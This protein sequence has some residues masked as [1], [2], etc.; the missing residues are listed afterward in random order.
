VPRSKRN[1]ALT[2]NF[3]MPLAFARAAK[4][5]SVS[6]FMFVSS[7]GVHGETS[8][9]VG[10]T[11]LSPLAAHDDYVASKAAA[12]KALL[13]AGAEIPDLT[14]IRPPMVYGPG[15]KGPMR[16]LLRCIE[17]GIP[18]P[19]GALTGNRRKMI[20]LSNLVDVLQHSGRR[21][22]AANQ[23]FLVADNEEL[24]TV[25]LLRLAGEACGRPAALPRIPL[26]M[27]NSA[28]RLP[29]VGSKLRRLFG[30]YQIDDGK[31]RKILHWTAPS[32]VLAELQRIYGTART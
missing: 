28:T 5:R 32:T 17:R 2:D 22:E 10:F 29:A 1:K 12:E 20:G 21:P 18:L 26:A 13:G 9:G 16:Y 11:E 31:C 3:E 23:T 7:C 6:R 8:N 24:S 15:M 27:L 25:A 14:I 4:R 19:L 30:D